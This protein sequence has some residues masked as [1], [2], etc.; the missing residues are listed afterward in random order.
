MAVRSPESIHPVDAAALR[1][2]L[3][4][5]LEGTPRS[6]VE[7]DGDG[8]N[9]LYADDATLS[10]YDSV[11]HMHE[12]FGEIHGFV[13]LDYAEIDLFTDELFPVSEEARYLVTGLDLF[14]LVRVYVDGCAYFVAV[15]PDEPVYPVVRT[16]ERVVAGE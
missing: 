14:T 16:I 5:C 2:A 7:F 8:F 12:H 15:D 1:E 9:V 4:E 6:L 10:F 3:E 11:E 13:N